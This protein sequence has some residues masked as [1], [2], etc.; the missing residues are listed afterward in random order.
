MGQM[1]AVGE[2]GAGL[3]LDTVDDWKALIGTTWKDAKGLERR[4]I[5]FDDIRKSWTGDGCIGDLIWKRPHWSDD[6]TKRTWLPGFH[7][8]LR[9]AVRVS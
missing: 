6:K 1:V 9:K 7:Q 3:I 5:G 8:W 2:S 4:I